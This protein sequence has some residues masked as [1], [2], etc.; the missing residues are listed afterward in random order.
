[1][2]AGERR[3]GVGKQTYAFRRLSSARNCILTSKGSI[4][5]NRWRSRIGYASLRARGVFCSSKIR[6]NSLKLQTS[7]EVERNT[8]W[9]LVCIVD[10]ALLIQRRRFPIFRVLL[11]EGA[12]R[13]YSCHRD[14]VPGVVIR[15]NCGTPNLDVTKCL[16]TSSRAP[17]RSSLNLYPRNPLPR[18]KPLQRNDRA[19]R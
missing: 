11:D 16:P 1:M 18:R 7:S 12:Q 4:I 14:A 8:D 9:R 15:T 5:Q 2:L 3:L 10:F 6:G 17:S 13:L 19:R